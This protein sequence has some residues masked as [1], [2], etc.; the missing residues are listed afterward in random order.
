LAV[1]AVGPGRVDLR[2]LHADPIRRIN[3]GP[4]TITKEA[5]ATN[6]ARR[7]LFAARKNPHVRRRAIKRARSISAPLGRLRQC[8]RQNSVRS[9]G[10]GL[11][12]QFNSGRRIEQGGAHFQRGPNLRMQRG[13]DRFDQHAFRDV[14]LVP[15][16]VFQQPASLTVS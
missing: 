3:I 15:K 13:N 12:I 11:G 7:D 9:G 2:G 10:Q 1:L 5:K 4:S 14:K 16:F 6:H 8:L